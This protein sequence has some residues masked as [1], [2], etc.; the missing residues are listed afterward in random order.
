[1]VHFLIKFRVLY[2]IKIARNTTDPSKFCLFII[3]SY[4]LG[5]FGCPL[6]AVVA[7]LTAEGARQ[8]HIT[9]VVVGNSEAHWW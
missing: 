6:L 8:I 7:T 3:Y 1:M 5:A 4:I 9:W 2:V